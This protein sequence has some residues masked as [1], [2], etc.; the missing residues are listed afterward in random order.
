MRARFERLSDQGPPIPGG[1]AEHEP[2][3]GRFG[4]GIRPGG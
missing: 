3:A 4:R 1:V 2:H